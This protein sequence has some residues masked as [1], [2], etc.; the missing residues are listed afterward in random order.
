MTALKYLSLPNLA[1]GAP[2]NLTPHLGHLDADALGG[3]D[4]GCPRCGTACTH[5]FA[6]LHHPIRP[7]PNCSG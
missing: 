5:G 4:L 1:T 7:G 3:I 6:A 2:E